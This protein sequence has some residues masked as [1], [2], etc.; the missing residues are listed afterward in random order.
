MYDWSDCTKS[1]AWGI[2]TV[3]EPG[4][5][6]QMR[7]VREV[8]CAKSSARISVCFCKGKGCPAT[9]RSFNNFSLINAYLF[10]F[11]NICLKGLNWHRSLSEN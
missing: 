10:F 3:C 9:S 1:P 7:R 5:I 11:R 4:H 6:S 2:A 8:E